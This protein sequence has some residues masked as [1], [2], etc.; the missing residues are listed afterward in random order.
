MNRWMKHANSVEKSRG[1]MEWNA[2]K[3]MEANDSAY[4]PGVDCSTT[5]CTLSSISF[6]LLNA[7]A[8]KNERE[9]CHTSL[10][11]NGEPELEKL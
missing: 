2:M 11:L 4:I 9:F 3:R 6:R 10:F 8:H 5:F 7:F 1:G